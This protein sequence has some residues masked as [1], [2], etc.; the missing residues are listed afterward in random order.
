MCGR[1]RTA[2]RAD[3]LHLSLRFLQCL[4]NGRLLSALADF[5]KAGREGPETGLGFDGAPAEKNVAVPLRNTACDDLWIMVMN[6]LTGI[7]D[8]PGQVVA[9]GNLLRNWST[10]GAAIVHNEDVSRE[11]YV[12]E[13][14]YERRFTNDDAMSMD[15][16]KLRFFAPCPRG[17]EGVLEQELHDLGVPMTTKT[18]GGVAFQ[19]PWSTCIGSISRVTLPAACSGKSDRPP[20]ARKTMCTAQPITCPGRTGSRRHRPSR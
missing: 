11:T 5:H 4:T 16:T 7:A 10:A 9:G 1:L 2:K 8:E 20:I 3:T 17:L 19:A 18:D 6:G 14:R 13:A 12:R 15:S